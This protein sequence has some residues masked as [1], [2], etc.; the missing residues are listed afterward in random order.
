VSRKKD[1]SDLTLF[2]P[3]LLVYYYLFDDQT[4]LEYNVI[5]W[6][7]VP[8][9]RREKCRENAMQSRRHNFDYLQQLIGSLSP[10]LSHME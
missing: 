5:L 3:F 8:K 2:I 4:S 6:D 7:F 10:A 9:W 1:R